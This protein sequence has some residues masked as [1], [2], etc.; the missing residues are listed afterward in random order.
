MAA[1]YGTPTPS[2]FRSPGP[3]PDFLVDK[4]ALAHLKFDPTPEGMQVMAILLPAAL[5]AS[6]AHFFNKA[7]ATK[8]FRPA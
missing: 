6:Y 1:S 8:D 3:T 2:T 5:G 4:T 7:I